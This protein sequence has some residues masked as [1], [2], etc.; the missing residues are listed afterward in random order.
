MGLE[1][2]AMLFLMA[3]VTLVFSVWVLVLWPRSGGSPGA[4]GGSTRP[5]A[6]E[7]AP[8]TLEGVLVAQLASGQINRQQYQHAME[9][10]AARDDERHPLSVPPGA[11]PAAA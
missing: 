10:L 11:D 2:I 3:M 4:A 9:G 6:A 1:V 8:Q 7:P 5:A